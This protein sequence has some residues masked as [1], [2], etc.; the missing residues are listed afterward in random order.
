MN[1][2]KDVLR[3]RN[4]QEI[5]LTKKTKRGEKDEYIIQRNQV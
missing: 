2:I 4:D 1:E 3:Y 5:L